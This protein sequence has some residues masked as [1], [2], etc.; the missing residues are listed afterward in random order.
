MQ[1]YLNLGGGSGISEYE[2]WDDYIKVKF[3]DDS[4][5]LYDYS[6]PG[7]SHVE[8]MKRLAQEGSG[9]NSYIRKYVKK[10]FAAQLQ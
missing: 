10:N 3:D 7:Q 2:I 1:K 6:A 5:Y 9:L 8:E 4:I